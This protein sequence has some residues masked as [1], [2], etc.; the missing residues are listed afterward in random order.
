MRSAGYWRGSYRLRQGDRDISGNVR[1]IQAH[2]ASAAAAAAA[3]FDFM[4]RMLDDQHVEF[5]VC[6]GKGQVPFLH[7]AF[8]A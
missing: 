5:Y 8:Q 4:Y 1:H 7:S 2:C 3:F 6:A